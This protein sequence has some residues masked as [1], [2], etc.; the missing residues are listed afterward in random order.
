MTAGRDEVVFEQR[1]ADRQ[2]ES[3]PLGHLSL[4]IGHLHHEDFQ[5][6]PDHLN[7]HFAQVA[8]WVRHVLDLHRDRPVSTCFLVDDYFAP[9]DLRSL[10]RDPSRVI[11]A[12]R[13]AAESNGLTID[14]VARE[15]ACAAYNDPRS[16][17]PPT[18]PARILVGKLVA[19]PPP[20]TYG[21]RPA[22][23]ATG[24]LP[25]GERSAGT[26]EAMSAAP[27]RPPRQSGV[28][29]HSIFMDVQ[30]WDENDS[31]RTWS[32]AFLAAVWQVLR[33]G[34]LREDGRGVALAQPWDGALPRLWD[35]LPPVVQVSD[36]K[37][38]F[39]A[40]HTMS[41][42]PNRFLPIEHAVR[43]VLDQLKVESRVVTEIVKQAKSTG[44]RLPQQVSDRVGYVFFF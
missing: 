22:P 13:A 28:H 14:Y 11:P 8:P 25:N 24:W 23:Q 38:P 15:S 26:T 6:G 7:R 31:G 18:E 10:V 29:R 33:L 16:A 40:F 43:T 2:L 17:Q 4:E 39:S 44:V 41:L 27:W 21:Y 37:V 1:N 20:G 32:C 3:V 12:L 19:D 42:L 9:S 35:E 30:L 5:K 34:L 36:T